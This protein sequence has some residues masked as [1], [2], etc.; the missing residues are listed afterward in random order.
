MWGNVPQRN[1]NFTGREDLLSDLRRRIV[2][3]EVTALLPH[4]LHGM[5]GV[6]KTQLAIEYVYRYQ[7]DYDVVWWIAADQETLVRS[8]LAGLAPRLGLTDIAPG[9][10]EDAVTAVLDA[11]RRGV[12]YERWL[13]VFDNADQPESMRALIPHG[14]G[15]VLVTSRNHRWEGVAD[16]VEVDVFKREESLTFLGRRV[17]HITDPDDDQLAKELGDLPLALEQ[18]GALLAE[19]MMSVKTY[20]ELLKEAATKILGENPPASYPV[21]VAA[22]WSVSVSRVKNETPD[23]MELLWRCA[24]FGP[25]PIP[26]ELLHRARYVLDGPLK[27]IL[28]DPLR[29]SR[30]IRTLGRYALVRVDNRH[31]TLQVHRIIQKLLRDDISVEEG[32]KIRHEV[33]LLLAAA[34]PGDPDDFANWPKYADLLSHAIPSRQLE[35]RQPDGRILARNIVR[36]LYIAGDYETAKSSAEWALKRWV[37]DSGDDHPDVLMMRRHLGNVLFALSDY[38][39]AYNLNKH[40]LEQMRAVLGDDHEE[41][42]MLTNSHG[43]DLR[44]R[45]EFNAA[46]ELDKDSVTRHRDV[47]GDDHPRTFMAASNLA[48]D[49]RIIG[50]YSISLQLHEQNYRDRLDFYSRDDH[51]RVLHS[52]DHVARALRHAGDYAKALEIEERVYRDYQETVRQRVL[53]N[54]H[55][56]VLG[57]AKSL[58][59]ARRKAGTTAEALEL[60]S[61][62]YKKYQQRYGVDHP[63]TLAAALNLGNARRVTGDLDGAATLIEEAVRRYR[64]VLGS[65]HPYTQGAV[66]NH[67]IARRLLGDAAHAMALLEEALERLERI[68]GDEHDYTLSCATNLASAVADVGDTERA[69]ELGE[70]TLQKFRESLGKDNPHTLACATNLALDLRA[71]GQEEVAAELTTETLNRYWGTLGK[72]HPTVVAA[73]QGQRLDLDFDPP[74]L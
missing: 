70:C 1:K 61:K 2:D 72:D 40:T 27:E 68:I 16:T 21:P 25:E 37:A 41:T 13:L 11:L 3:E 62:V 67:A 65:D 14:P 57:Q 8:A 28:G 6:G 38:Q 20:L 52:L 35:C 58:S 23:A 34:D 49:Y 43:A 9:R 73:A 15:H 48:V 39:G 55:P 59:I 63:D 42:L 64:T 30:A 46:F 33:H 10:T 19:S 18:A 12:P 60:A 66:M 74:P 4:A 7:A 29:L 56:W 22:A 32:Y 69:R 44:A 17:P 26:I 53:P 45:G 5:G 50:H 51:P 36:W 31:N 71:L 47:F 24:F 54:D